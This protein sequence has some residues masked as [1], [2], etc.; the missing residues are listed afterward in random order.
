MTL[1]RAIVATVVAWAVAIAG[2]WAL[3]TALGEGAV[4]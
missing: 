2:T 3:V 1:R 4:R